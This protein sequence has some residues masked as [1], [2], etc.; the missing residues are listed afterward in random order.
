MPEVA[1]TGAA[2]EAGLR[3]G[4]RS[5][6]FQRPLARFR[7]AGLKEEWTSGPGLDR[8]IGARA[9]PQHI[10]CQI[11][12]NQFPECPFWDF[13]V[14]VYGREGV[15][16]ACLALQER[17]G[18]D[19]NFLLYCCWLGVEGC[20]TLDANGLLR[21]TAEVERWHCEVV[22]SLRAVRKYL[23]ANPERAS[24]RRVEPLRRKIQAVELEAE[25][26]EQIMLYQLPLPQS[27]E[28]ATRDE[29]IACSLENMRSYLASA[30]AKLDDQ[31]VSDLEILLAGSITECE[32]AATSS[33][34]TKP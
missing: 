4:D 6:Q 24:V 11:G 10:V 33:P 15:A 2:A 27:R 32:R 26:I 7:Q 8:T 19:V 22:R 25:H 18:A 14:A 30:G 5:P 29:R 23:R 3:V 1:A 16:A 21:A 28:N 9:G 34:P 13:S 31:D 20:R 12:M 17:H